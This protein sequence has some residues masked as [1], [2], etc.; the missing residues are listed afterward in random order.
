MIFNGFDFT[1]E[2]FKKCSLNRQRF[3]LSNY[4]KPITEEQFVAEVA[5]W[6][7]KELHNSQSRCASAARH[8][9]RRLVRNYGFFTP[10][11]QPA[12]PSFPNGTA[13]A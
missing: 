12:K 7:R 6:P 1:H 11:T 10:V 9:Y 13:Q 8:D 4:D 3:Y 5:S 2:D